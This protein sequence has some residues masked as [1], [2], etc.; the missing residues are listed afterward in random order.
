MNSRVSFLLLATAAAVSCF[1]VEVP[2]ETYEQLPYMIVTKGARVNTGKACADCEIR[3]R[4]WP[5][6]Y[7]HGQHLFGGN[8]A[9]QLQLTMTQWTWNWGA[10]GTECFGDNTNPNEQYAD[11]FQDIIFNE[12]GT[13]NLIINGKQV[14]ST[15]TVKGAEC[16]NRGAVTLF[17]RAEAN[18]CGRFYFF[19]AVA[20]NKA[21]VTDLVP[22]RR[23]SD[24][25][26]GVFDQTDGRFLPNEGTGLFAAPD[27]VFDW[28]PSDGAVTLG[29]VTVTPGDKTLTLVGPN[30][31][32]THWQGN[33][34]PSAADGTWA[35]IYQRRCLNDTDIDVV[36]FAAL[37]TSHLDNKDIQGAAVPRCVVREDGKLT[38]QMQVFDGTYTKA[39]KLVLKQD[40]ADIVG[41]VAW[42]KRYK[43]NAVGLDMETIDGVEDVMVATEKTY[44][45]M[46]SGYGV[47][48]LLMKPRHDRM[49][50]VRLSEPMTVDTV[51][52]NNGAELIAANGSLTQ[53]N[54]SLPATI[55]MARGSVVVEVDDAHP[56]NLGSGSTVK[57]DLARLEFRAT[58]GDFVTGGEYTLTTNIIVTTDFS[59]CVLRN[60]RLADLVDARGWLAGNWLWATGGNDKNLPAW[61]LDNR[62]DFATCQFQVK[63]GTM[64][65]GVMLE[66]QQVGADVQMRTPWGKVI[67]WNDAG[68][69]QYT[70]VGLFRFTDTAGNNQPIVADP[71]QDGY[72]LTN[73]V[74][75]FK[76][77]PGTYKPGLVTLNG[78][79]DGA[80]SVEYLFAGA[81]GRELN[82]EVAAKSAIP[83]VDYAQV[84]VNSNAVLKLKV[85]DSTEYYGLNT[86]YTPFFVNGGE[87][88]N[89]G[90]Y[91]LGWRRVIE[92]DGGKLCLGAAHPYQEYEWSTIRYLYCLN[93]SE[94]YGAKMRAGDGDS[95]RFWL[96][97]RGTSPS[98]L[99]S[100][101]M[102]VCSTAKE[103][104]FDVA[105]V[106]GD[107][108]PDFI[109][110]GTWNWYWQYNQMT[111]VKEGDG[112]LRMTG[113]F[114]GNTNPI[115]LN[116]GLVE[117]AGGNV[118]PATTDFISNGGGLS[119]ASGY[120]CSVNSLTLTD[121]SPFAVPANATLT[122]ADMGE[123]TPG[124]LLSITAPKGASVR[125]C[126]ASE[127]TPEMVS[128]VRI[129][130]KKCSMDANGYL[131][132]L[133]GLLFL[134]R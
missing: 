40:H 43:G 75:T 112:T 57:G 85:A 131:Y 29:E 16:Y 51:T 38:A 6:K 45:T 106:T 102:A 115:Y 33:Y 116:G 9:K 134:L 94:I 34:L 39:V 84:V 1:A 114:S 90:D 96:C 48:F 76:S 80:F 125:L 99:R 28:S 61:F 23:R 113:A 92:L 26:V 119:V 111:Y 130:R 60:T 108:R 7:E 133:D 86:G 31:G 55:Q 110:D 124:K 95:P 118:F 56:A 15:G 69:T 78:A 35:T 14:G 47:D 13:G 100:G 10:T 132:A 50:K 64:I 11:G 97:V 54:E 126:A 117:V 101:F 62:G 12:L 123:W 27:T 72:C 71:S 37:Y 83:K 17:F 82:A 21:V 58:P 63:S 5:W 18:Y 25:V 70:D 59:G 81:D 36:N 19:K 127:M 79:V 87:L 53:A 66:L 88:R 22:C 67:N 121:D 104:V 32:S 46:K 4:F 77:Q 105:D 65:K 2:T 44:P 120:T 107:S 109:V 93:G 3:A 52:V 42:A 98:Y 91:N 122:F 41:Q 89:E 129:N 128:S 30:Q 20:Q 24:G 73:L 8:N 103:L 49:G 68:Y 74:L